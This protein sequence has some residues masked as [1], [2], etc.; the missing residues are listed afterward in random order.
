MK[1]RLFL[2]IILS[3]FI[4]AIS[5]GDE[6]Y[7]STLTVSLNDVISGYEN[8]SFEDSGLKAFLELNLGRKIEPW[9]PKSWD[10]KLLTVAAFYYQP[11]LD[12]A[13]AKWGIEKAGI[14]TAGGRLNPE[15]GF[16]PQYNIN[17]PPGISPWTLEFSMDIPIETAHKRGYRTALSKNISDS[18]RFK[19]AGIV[20]QTYYRVKANMLNLYKA[21]KTDEIVQEK[22]KIQEDISRKI[23]DRL[24]QGEISP[25]LATETNISLEQTRLLSNEAQRQIIKARHDLAQSIGVPV[26]ALDKIDIS[27]DFLD[28]HISSD[29]ISLPEI[30]KQ[31]LT[32]RADLLGML[33]E[34]DAIGS[35]INLE[36]S[37][38]NPDFRIGSDYTWD[39]GNDKWGLALSVPLPVLNQNQGPIAENYAR[40]K[41]IEQ[42]F[43]V[44]QER[45]ISDANRNYEI[46]MFDLK[47]LI[48]T[49]KLLSEKK[50][51]FENTEKRVKR[52]ETTEISLLNAQLEVLHMELSHLDALVESRKSLT[53]IEDITQRSFDISIDTLTLPETKP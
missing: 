6:V 53:E 11:E 34:Y 3:V 9:P 52:T 22:I 10:L 7:S 36:L 30:K 43:N 13:R 39:Q 47:T 44:L 5:I 16:K 49:D 41:E 42:Q 12:I 26:N 38:K 20:W 1:L 24:T 33:S 19:I 31:A 25:I 15:F 28:K 35:A 37:K 23:K 45:I 8:R 21:L 18:A 46:Y 50:Q 51:Q 27:Y 29:S 40:K 4:Q 14:I 2:T 48:R 32:N 17:N